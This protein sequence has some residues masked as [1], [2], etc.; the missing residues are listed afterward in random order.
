[1]PHSGCD[2]AWHKRKIADESMPDF[3]MEH[4]ASEGAKVFELALGIKKELQA[5]DVDAYAMLH[6][7]L[8]EPDE[9]AKHESF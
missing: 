6:L 8:R 5:D 2:E 9:K 7:P 4:F 1:M 3:G